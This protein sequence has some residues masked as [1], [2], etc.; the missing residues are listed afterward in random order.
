LAWGHI[1]W[2]AYDKFKVASFNADRI[3]QNNKRVYRSDHPGGAQFVFVDGSV[4]F[5]DE[6]IEYPTLRA[7]V[8]RAG[9]EVLAGF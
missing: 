8:T 1:D 9:E 3:L 2:L 4:R 5:L 7:L 6:S